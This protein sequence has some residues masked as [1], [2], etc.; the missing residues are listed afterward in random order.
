MKQFS[1]A[2]SIA[3]RVNSIIK[4]DIESRGE[5]WLVC[6][7]YAD[8]NDYAQS[9]VDRASYIGTTKEHVRFETVARYVRTTK[10]QIRAKLDLAAK[11]SNT[12]QS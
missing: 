2:S 9:V 11:Q 3:S 12:V 1:K 5:T 10:A 6:L 4:S 8:C 7:G